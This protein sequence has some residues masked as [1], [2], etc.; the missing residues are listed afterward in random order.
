MEKTDFINKI[1]DIPLTGYL[2]LSNEVKPSRVYR[3]VKIDTSVFDV[4]NPFVAE[5]LLY[6]QANNLSYQIKYID[7]KYRIFEGSTQ[8]QNADDVI[9]PK[10][11][12]AHS[13]DGVEKLKFAQFFT[14]Q[15]DDGCIDM[16]VLK[17]DRVVFV[18]FE[19]KK[20][21]K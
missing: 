19:D 5:G 17:L 20:E 18:G 10:S 14:L 21:V 3:N 8:K 4:D 11:F 12:I 1:K 13:I 2:W 15:K 16:K 6:D 9:E 7:N